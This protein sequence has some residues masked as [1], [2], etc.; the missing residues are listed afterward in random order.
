MTKNYEHG[1]RAFFG[2]NGVEWSSF[3]D[4]T[5]RIIMLMCSSEE[6]V[7]RKGGKV[8]LTSTYGA[9]SGIEEFAD[10]ILTSL[11]HQIQVVRHTFL[12]C[13]GDNFPYFICGRNFCQDFY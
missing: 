6:E 1:R 7:R 13:R 9:K 10:A 11:M 8:L 12:V 3:D 2:R 5:P 4:A